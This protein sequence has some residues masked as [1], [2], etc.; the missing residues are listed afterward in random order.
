MK[1][2]YFAGS[3]AIALIFITARAHTAHAAIL[4]SSDQA[5]ASGQDRAQSN[6]DS[7]VAV[8]SGSSQNMTNQR[9]AGSA[10][11]SNPSGTV[12]PNI[13]CG[14]DDCGGG[15][16]PGTGYTLTPSPPERFAVSPGGVD[17]RT[18]NYKYDH[19]DLSVGGEKGLELHRTASPRS[20]QANPQLFGGFISNWSIYVTQMRDK[21][22]EANVPAEFDYRVSVNY[23]G[24]S[25]TF[26]AEYGI[27]DGFQQTSSDLP[28]TLTF[29]GEED[30]L[31]TPSKYIYIAND[32]TRA[33]FRPIMG[34]D[35][36]IEGICAS[37]SEITEP[38][39]AHYDFTYDM[40]GN[41]SRLRSVVS[42]RGYA[43]LLE[44]NVSSYPLLVSKACVLNL[45]TTA[46]PDVTAVHSCPSGATSS[47]YSYS[48]GL[49]HS[50][51][52]Q[53]GVSTLIG[54]HASAI[55]NPGEA[56]PYVQNTFLGGVDGPDNIV[57]YQS[58][59]DGRTYAYTW[60]RVF[61]ST[62]GGNI[63]G[64]IFIDNN[65]KSASV[66]Y[67]GI[68]EVISINPS[69]TT[70][71]ITPQ[72]I[73]ITD[74]NGNTVLG[75]FTDCIGS[76][77]GIGP[78][79]EITNPEGD[80]KELFYDYSGHVIQTVLHAKPG[81]GL[82]DIVTSAT[83]S[84]CSNPLICA[85]PMTTTDARGKVTNFTYDP[86]TGKVRYE[87]DP[88]D[89]SGVRPGKYYTYVERYAW[90]KSGSGYAHASSP[91]WLPATMV[92]CRT[93]ALN[94]TAGTCGGGAGDT[95]TTSYDY[96]PDAGPNNLLLRGVA[97]TAGG[98]T[99]RTC[100]GYDAAGDKIWE[101]KPN[102]G[103]ASCS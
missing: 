69:I 98:V 41:A 103:L 97:V 72:P 24:K 43:L 65:G 67:Q 7:V 10:G 90:I 54:P 85:E 94:T 21:T 100:Y 74:Q 76:S 5:S 80:S 42:N 23:G 71:K 1:G 34:G 60:N 75:N 3:A 84:D 17:M 73:S 59:S 40:S 45:A 9:V 25:A 6:D 16:G 2:F 26:K 22:P 49:L 55:Y 89:V 50:F 77:C 33:V 66:V 81:S 11:D 101:T 62:T 78:L 68:G 12:S 36:M 39:G 56:S 61:Y 102:A 31:K 28:S 96:G 83:Y 64:G 47:T 52:D 37:A 8:D 15:G 51:V 79:H 27:I 48:S 4:A 58:F 91:V 70:T 14:F 44:Y 46:M 95:V 53:G 30:G 20:A 87:L 88:A 92:T 13:V 35:C 63:A 38:D 19:L 32:G 29:E 57:A 99:E 86:N 93:T 82:A 18:G